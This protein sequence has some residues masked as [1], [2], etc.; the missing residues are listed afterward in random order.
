M[1]IKYPLDQEA[2]ELRRLLSV[3]GN[4]VWN[5][6]TSDD[7]YFKLNDDEREYIIMLIN[8]INND[9]QLNDYE[10]KERINYLKNLV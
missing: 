8:K 3:L 9:P 10:K 2:K 6:H 7:F 5:H 1:S 4:F